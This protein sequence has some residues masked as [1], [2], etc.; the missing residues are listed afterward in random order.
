MFRFIQR[1]TI[2]QALGRKA[3]CVRI[4]LASGGLEILFVFSPLSST[5]KSIFRSQRNRL[6]SLLHSCAFVSLFPLPSHFS[7]SPPLFVTKITICHTYPLSTSL[8]SQVW[9]P[10]STKIFFPSLTKPMRLFI[11]LQVHN[12]EM[13]FIS[14]VTR[15]HRTTIPNRNHLLPHESRVQITAELQYARYSK[16][17]TESCS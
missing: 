6:N 14:S 16:S 7:K 17:K 4:M 10:L 13:N 15:N 8:C 5:M 2:Y 12:S 9:F 11:P 1:L 3:E